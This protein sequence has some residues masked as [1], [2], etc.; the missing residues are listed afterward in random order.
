MWLR[1][2]NV[3]AKNTCPFFL[4]ENS[5]PYLLLESPRPFS[6]PQGTWTCHQP[7]WEL[8]LSIPT[9]WLRAL[10]H[11]QSLWLYHPQDTICSA[12]NPKCSFLFHPV[13]STTVLEGFRRTAVLGKTP[14][15]WLCHWE[16]PRSSLLALNR[17]RLDSSSISRS[18]RSLS[19]FL[20]AQAH[21][22]GTTC[23][24]NTFPPHPRQS[25]NGMF[26]PP[27]SVLLLFT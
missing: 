19:C 12:Q 14:T 15:F 25:A 8:T 18:V 1:L 5:D 7:A 11:P 22:C 20:G 2:R 10:H 9:P 27:D 6:P 21:G 24:Q 26:F 16:E 4:L 13:Y 3:K 23:L 17:W